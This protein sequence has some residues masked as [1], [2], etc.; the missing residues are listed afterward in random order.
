MPRF[1]RH[2]GSHYKICAVDGCRYPDHQMRERWDG[3]LVHEKNWEPR[4][5][6]EFLRP[7]KEDTSVP[8]PRTEKGSNSDYGT[9]YD[10]AYDAEYW[11]YQLTTDTGA[12]IVTDDDYN[13]ITPPN[14]GKLE[15]TI[16]AGTF[17]G[18]L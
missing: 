17:D 4:H 3:L 14:A 12:M 9:G 15:K 13:I 11:T 8:D 5:P 10:Y 16:P 7:R 2:A 18:S 1:K 6:Q